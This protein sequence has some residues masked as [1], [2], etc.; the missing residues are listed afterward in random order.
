MGK[1]ESPIPTVFG[2]RQRLEGRMELGDG[3]KRVG[4]GFGAQ[5]QQNVDQDVDAQGVARPFAI[6]RIHG[7]VADGSGWEGE[8]FPHVFTCTNDNSFI[9]SDENT[10]F[11]RR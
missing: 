2:I 4:K 10:S 11:T 5:I 7:A 1:V 9:I 6:G 8:L 3:G